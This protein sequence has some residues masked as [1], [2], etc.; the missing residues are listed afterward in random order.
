LP[1]D[2]LLKGDDIDPCGGTSPTAACQKIKPAKG[3]S[4]PVEW[5]SRKRSG[6][7]RNENNCVKEDRSLT[8]FVLTLN[9]PHNIPSRRVA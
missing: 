6:K 8:N 5:E 7:L 1:K 4:R 3:G 9:N 2:G